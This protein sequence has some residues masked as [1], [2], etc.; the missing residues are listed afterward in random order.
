MSRRFDSNELADA[1]QTLGKK[2][3][4][5][6]AIAP[7]AD[8]SR[9]IQSIASTLGKIE[10]TI[11]RDAQASG[12]TNISLTLFAAR[13]LELYVRGKKTQISNRRMAEI[14]YKVLC[15]GVEQLPRSN[16]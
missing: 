15:A 4:D 1:L 10:K 7:E 11:G 13:Q 8:A 2:I 9:A 3:Q 5:P 6:E 12:S 14:Y 16:H